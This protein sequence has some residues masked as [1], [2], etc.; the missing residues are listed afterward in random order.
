M[1]LTTAA[2][3]QRSTNAIRRRRILVGVLAAAV[4]IVAIA[5]YVLSTG[6]VF[7]GHRPAPQEAGTGSEKKLPTVPKTGVGDGR[8]VAML[9]LDSETTERSVGGQR[10]TTEVQRLPR[11][12]LDLTINLPRGLEGGQYELALSKDDNPPLLTITGQAKIEDGL[13]VLRVQP[14]L[15]G[16]SP[17]S[18]RLRIRREGSTWHDSEVLLF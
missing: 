6:I 4:V 10:H 14:D 7:P 17:G 5:A 18:Y 1:E 16:L 8:F 13:T 15:S 12:R 3:A 11:K 9:N 2:D